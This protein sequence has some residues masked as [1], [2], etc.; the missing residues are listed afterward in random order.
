MFVVLFK[1]TDF[2]KKILTVWYCV[3]GD[4]V[5]HVFFLAEEQSMFSDYL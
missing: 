2:Q 1:G 5:D 4:G 3:G